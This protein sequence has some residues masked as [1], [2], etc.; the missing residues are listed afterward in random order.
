MSIQTQG[1]TLT[2]ASIDGDAGLK[3]ALAM[4]RA[5]IIDMVD[6][7]GMK[8]RGGAGFPTGMKWNFAGAE[9]GRPQ[10]HHLQRRRG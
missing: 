4:S 5:D 8:G 6:D 10:V 2:F 7:S 3:A 9:K 1:N